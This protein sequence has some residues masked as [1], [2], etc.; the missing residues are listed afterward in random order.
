M[1]DVC[2]NVVIQ[3][4]TC[5]NNISRVYNNVH[6][7][8]GSDTQIPLQFGYTLKFLQGTA[9]FATI[10]IINDFFMP[11]TNFNIPNGSYRVFDLPCQCGTF[12]VFIGMS[13]GV[14][15]YSSLVCS[16]S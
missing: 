9:N 1:G 5:E 7:N 8:I 16:G 14:C 11:A 3:Q 12:R 2:Y 4:H 13:T 6:T 15:S 10:Q